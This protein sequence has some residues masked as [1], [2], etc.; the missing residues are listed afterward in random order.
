MNCQRLHIDG[1]NYSQN[2]SCYLFKNLW[3]EILKFGKNFEQ[4]WGW[5]NLLGDGVDLLGDGGN[6]LSDG[7]DLLGDGGNLLGD[8]GNLKLN[9]RLEIRKCDWPTNGHG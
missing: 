5:G 9:Q 8:G 7:G 4:A 2:Q 3:H 1:K 6:L